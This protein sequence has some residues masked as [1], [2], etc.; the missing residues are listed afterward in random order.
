MGYWR[1]VEHR[2][3]QRSTSW[4][5][6]NNRSWSW[7]YRLSCFQLL[8]GL[9]NG[10]IDGGINAVLCKWE[11]TCAIDSTVFELLW[12]S[13]LVKVKDTFHQCTEIW[14]V[15]MKEKIIS[16]ERINRNRIYSLPWTNIVSINFVAFDWQFNTINSTHDVKISV[17]NTGDWFTGCDGNW[18]LTVT[19]L[20]D[21]H[22]AVWKT[23]NT[24]VSWS[25]F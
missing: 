11:W 25:Y 21:W 8:W 19:G 23:V 3:H 9:W 4:P 13:C 15:A 12:A 24:D 6:W 22:W 2:N 18:Q 5:H 10:N 7:L 20:N 14:I 1:W 16:L 17:N